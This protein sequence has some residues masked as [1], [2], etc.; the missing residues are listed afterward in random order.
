M[1]LHRF[2]F[3]QVGE[4]EALAHETEAMGFDGLMLSDSQNL[5]SDPYIALTLAARATRRILLGTAATNLETRHPAVTACAVATLDQIS[6]GR[7]L[8]GVGRGDTALSKL[9]MSPCPLPAFGARLEELQAYLR[10]ETVGPSPIDWLQGGRKV[11]VSLFASGPK[12]MAL[13]SR[14]TENVTLAL[15]ADPA[16]VEW[17]VR[18]CG[19]R[20]GAV[21]ILGLGAHGVEL[22]RGN[23]EVFARFGRAPGVSPETSD[24]FVER[25]AVVGEPEM[26]VQRLVELA[27]LGLDHMLVVGPWKT[28]DPE[29]LAEHERLLPGVVGAVSHS[30]RS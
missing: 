25:Y 4:V 20:A 11:P 8:L 3:T 14:L 15:G 26:C 13:G 22:V 24:A 9:G 21:V 7:A 6:G 5:Q 18:Q 29:Q 19:T 27:R 10:G 28:A 1:L 30:L 2:A 12:A 23:V 17:G 16:W